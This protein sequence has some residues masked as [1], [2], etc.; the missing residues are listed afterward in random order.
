MPVPAFPNLPHTWDKLLFVVGLVFIFFNQG[1]LWFILL[2][3][4]LCGIGAI[5][6]LTEFLATWTLNPDPTE[7]E[8]KGWLK[9]YFSISGLILLLFLFLIGIILSRL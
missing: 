5:I 3:I 8:K 6:G 9:L 4:F 7:D 1:N 2:G